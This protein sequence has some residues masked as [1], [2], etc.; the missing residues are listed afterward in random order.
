MIAR[1]W[2]VAR[3]RQYVCHTY[4]SDPPVGSCCLSHCIMPNSFLGRCYFVVCFLASFEEP[5]LA[6]VAIRIHILFI[7]VTFSKTTQSVS[8]SLNVIPLRAST[9]TFD[10]KLKLLI[11]D[12][13][14]N[15]WLYILFKCF[16]VLHS[17]IYC[18][19]LMHGT[20][21]LFDMEKC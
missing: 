5:L 16:D 9:L 14:F 3:A 15:F 7:A 20:S 21:K 19:L 17:R 13:I 8:A 2:P 6:L 12:L 18:H 4:S 1:C 10:V 11:S